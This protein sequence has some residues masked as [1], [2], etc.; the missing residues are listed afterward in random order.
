[1]SDEG[2][3]VSRPVPFGAKELFPMPIPVIVASG[4]YGSGKS[5]FGLS[6]CPMETMLYDNEDSSKTYYKQLGIKRRLSMGE[7]ML[8]LY[9][10][11]YRPIQVFEWWHKDIKKIQPGEYRVIMIDPAS[12]LE[13]GIAD[14]VRANPKQFGVSQKQIDNAPSLFLW[15]NVKMHWNQILQELSAKCE[16]VYLVMHLKNEFQGSQ[17][18]GKK[19]P[20]GLETLEELASLY[21]IFSRDRDPATGRTPDAPSARV[22]KSRLS[23]FKFDPETGN[24]STLSALTPRIPVCTVAEIRKIIARG[25]ID[26]ST[27]KPE[28][29]AAEEAMS[30]EDRAR[31]ELQRQE[32][33]TQEAQARAAF[34]QQ[35]A[36]NRDES[37]ARRAQEEVER[38]KASTAAA[39]G[40][41]PAN[42]SEVAAAVVANAATVKVPPPVVP[43]AAPTTNGTS[44]AASP[45]MITEEQFQKIKKM[46]GQAK[47][48]G[49]TEAD[50]KGI[51][52]KRQQADGQPV[53]SARGLSRKQADELIPGMEKLLVQ[54]KAKQTEGRAE[55]SPKS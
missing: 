19:I 1:M 14:Y 31:L 23:F 25:G 3:Y 4:K 33:A 13:Q 50:W 16:C 29:Q 8:K 15:P 38:L 43:A 42:L 22:H 21:L 40:P 52:G 36:R 17:A 51:L 10:E 34:E 2:H 11:G 55:P 9:P 32:L 30:D 49:M 45:E 54:L 27:L 46:H 47:E 18:T 20:K 48:M 6:I 37:R 35:V 26:Y 28:E 39:A 7:E 53:I 5:I 24:V 41:A 44:E 12:I